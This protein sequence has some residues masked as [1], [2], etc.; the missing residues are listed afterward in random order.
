MEFY[1]N[2]KKTKSAL[3]GVLIAFVHE[4]EAVF[5]LVVGLQLTL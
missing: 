5:T 4:F 3:K 2:R 1:I